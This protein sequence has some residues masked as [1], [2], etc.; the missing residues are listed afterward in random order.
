MYLF[1][2]RRKVVFLL[3][4]AMFLSGCFA[5][6]MTLVSTGAGAS[7]GRLIHSSASSAFSYGVKKTTGK[8][9]IEH[10]I[11]REKQRVAKKVSNFE[12]KVIENTRQKIE[13]SKEKILPVKNNVKNQITKL[14]N[15]LFKVKT[16]ALE[17]FKHK[18]RFSYKAR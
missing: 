2:M 10:I 14:D 11:I 5:Q 13:A 3:L 17:N 15:S 16:F 1:M 8:F 18:P 6:S 9:P 4:S 7:Q 12:K